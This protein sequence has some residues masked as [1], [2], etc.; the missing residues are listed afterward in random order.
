M[1]SAAAAACAAAAAAATRQLRRLR[2]NRCVGVISRRYSSTMATITGKASA[3]GGGWQGGRRGAVAWTPADELVGSGSRNAPDRQACKRP[4]SVPV[5]AAAVARAPPRACAA[6]NPA[7][8]ASPCLA[9][10]HAAD[11]GGGRRQPRH[12]RRVC[13]PVCCQGQPRDCGLQAGGRA[14]VP[15]PMLASQQRRHCPATCHHQTLTRPCC[16]HGPSRRAGVC[17]PPAKRLANPTQPP[18][19]AHCLA[20]AAAPQAAAAGARGAGPGGRGADGHRAGPAAAG[21]HRGLGRRAAAPGAALRRADQQR[22]WVLVTNAGGCWSPTRHS[23]W[24]EGSSPRVPHPRGFTPH[25]HPTG[26]YGRRVGIDEINYDD[27]LLAFTTNCVGPLLVVQQ[28]FK[29]VPFERWARGMCPARHGRAPARAGCNDTQPAAAAALQLAGSRCCCMRRRSCPRASRCDRCTPHTAPQARRA[30][31]RA[32]KPGGQRH[33]QSGQRGGQRQRRRLRIQASAA[34]APS[35]PALA[36]WDEGEGG[37]ALPRC[38][39]AAAARR[40]LPSEEVQLLTA[41]APSNRRR[42]SKSAMNITTKSLSIDLAPHGVTCT[43]LHPGAAAGQSVSRVWHAGR[44][45]RLARMC[46]RAHLDGLPA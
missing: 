9:T 37:R 6:L 28:L 45:P 17:T 38:A 19:G 5:S 8:P 15:A 11:R 42:A 43:L 44:A 1:G 34:H 41:T 26:V 29:C 46:W 22:G 2:R 39:G 21:E 4:S 18:T 30:G 27:M 20:A 7:F 31:R 23:A 33:F 35:C 12:R 13:A 14:A 16:I 10:A 36:R 24:A 40:S 32:A 25:T 3:A